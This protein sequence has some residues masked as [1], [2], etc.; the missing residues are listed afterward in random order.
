VLTLGQQKINTLTLIVLGVLIAAIA[1]L[2]V[3]EPA[4]LPWSFLAL[5]AV[6]LLLCWGVRW[7]VTLL[8]WFWV[9]SYGLLD[10][11]EWRITIRYFF[12]M[13]VPRFI[14]LAAVTGFVVHFLTHKRRI[15]WDRTIL[16]AMLALTIYCAISA[17]ATGWLAQTKAVQSA[18][19]FRFLGSMVFPFIIFFFVYNATRGEDQ[20]RRALLLVS[21]FGWYALYIGYLQYVAIMGAPE[22]RAFIWPPYINDP[23]HG[24][25]FDRARGSFGSG[26][27][28]AIL[29]IFLFYADLYLLRK[30]HGPY[31]AALAAQ[32]V[33]IPPAI[34]FTGMRSAYLAFFLCGAVWCLFA[35]RRRFG[36]T[37]L[38]LAAVLVALG[39]AVFWQN[40]AQTRRQ[41]GGL[42]QR[43]PVEARIVLLGQ[44]WQLVKEHPFTGVGF[45]HFADAQYRL[46]RDPSGLGSL[47]PGLLVEHNLFLSMLAE[48][49]IFGLL[50]TLAI[51][52]LL[53]RRSVQLYRKLPPTAQGWLDREFVT[54]FW[55]VLINYTTDAMF[56][57][58]YSDV[59]A[60]GLFWSFAGLM[61]GFNR[62]LEPRP[63]DLPV[64]SKAP[65]A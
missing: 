7:E 28:Q 58:T 20:I 60:N 13:T 8:A 19:Y 31:R 11:P 22:A 50:G 56:R 5:A 48:T 51:F 29:L 27:Q 52:V 15:R 35:A 57:D 23:A 32:A 41:T 45:G 40:L 46:Q 2:S 59:F 18:P 25:H 39:A 53:L 63:L 49:G 14:F 16:W 34:F 33:L 17:T 4:L 9:L 44:T 65:E 55:V 42:A 54:L 12:N 64:L 37:K 36:R 1:I 3:I 62:L 61:V 38:A 21:V 30:V 47:S 24:I 26:S 10:W 43:G 6:A